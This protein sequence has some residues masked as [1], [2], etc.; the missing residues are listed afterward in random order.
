MNLVQIQERLKDL[1]LSAV[2]NYANGANPEVPAY[3]ALGELKRR[4]TMEKDAAMHQQAAKGPQPTVKDQVEK[5]VGLMALQRQQQQQAQ[6]NQIQQ[7]AAQPQPVPPNIPQPAQQEQSEPEMAMAMG[8]VAALPVKNEMFEYGSGGIIAFA[9]ED[10]SQVPAGA[11]TPQEFAAEINARTDL[12]QEDKQAMISRYLAGYKN[13]QGAQQPAAKA[14]APAPAR[15]GLPAAM[16]DTSQSAALANQ[17]LAKEPAR[18]TAAGIV[19]EEQAL[20]PAELNTPYG[21]EAKKRIAG[22]ESLYKQQT[23]SRP[24]ER[25]MA[26]LAGIGRGSLGGAAPAYLSSVEAERAADMAHAQKMHEAL[27]GIEK[28][29]REEAK[30]IFGKRADMYKSA[31]SNFSEAERNRLTAAVQKFGY[32][33]AS[34]DRALERV[35]QLEVAK[36]QSAAANRPGETERLLAQYAALKGKDPAAAE[37][38]MRNIERI[39]GTAQRAETAK[40][41]NQIARMKIAAE[42]PTYSAAMNTATNPKADPVKRQ[43]AQDRMK[44]IERQLG[45]EEIPETS[46]ATSGNQKVLDFSKI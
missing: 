33:T 35:T 7:A 13:L 10:G 43:E 42:N 45:F 26:V 30:D 2:K 44:A 21:E 23:E 3:V 6:Q 40:E 18:P 38:M 27:T 39:R 20:R 19:Q 32:D 5:Q 16:P 17:L 29:G 14:A 31:M 9:G 34:A 41:K 11:K 4:E 46:G 8:G 15:A 25:L 12:S 24:Q 36:I 28:G 22:L 1:P 37:D